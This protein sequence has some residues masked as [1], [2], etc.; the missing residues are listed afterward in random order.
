[1]KKTLSTVALMALMA[2]AGCNNHKTDTPTAAND[3]QPPPPPNAYQ[4]MASSA[5]LN[6]NTSATVTPVADFSSTP[7]P[8]PAMAVDTA[9]VSTK[10]RHQVKAASSARESTHVAKADG[11]KYT[12]QKGDS[13]MKI[14]KKEYGKSGEYKKILAANPGLNPDKLM[15]GKTI[16]IPQ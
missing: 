15:V 6:N 12:I 8:A 2:A 1:V 14:A 7:A 10:A 16:V 5:N 4:P 11:K 9:P 13:L 3:L